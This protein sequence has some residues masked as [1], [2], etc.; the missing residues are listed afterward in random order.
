M[1][2][3]QAITIPSATEQAKP[4]IFDR[5]RFLSEAVLPVDWAATGRATWTS[6]SVQ[7]SSLAVHEV[8]QKAV[9]AHRQ[10]ERV[11]SLIQLEFQEKAIQE[12]TIESI[13][14]SVFLIGSFL[15]GPMPIP[16]ASSGSNGGTTLFFGEDEFYGD[17]E[18][19]GRFVDYYLKFEMNGDPVE[20]FDTEEIPE[21]SVPPKLL[22]CLF[23]HYARR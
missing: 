10:I 2:T 8:S 9:E 12:K 23:T 6:A 11:K 22:T 7:S 20:V 18:V 13:A 21:G 5:L 14:S 16:V 4:Q 19:N 15:T 3:K 17:L 1:S